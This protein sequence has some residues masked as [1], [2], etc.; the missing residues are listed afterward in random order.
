MIRLAILDD[1]PAIL[2]LI[3]RVVPLMR[4]TGNLQWDDQYPNAAVFENDIA[5]DQLWV[6][7]LDHQLVGLA[8]ITTDQE[9]EYAEVGWDLTETAVVVHR[10]AVDPAVRGRGIAA[11]LMNQAEEVA[12][13]RGISVLR[14]DTNTQNEATQRLFPKLGY[15]FAGEIGLSFRPG[16]RFYCYEKRLVTT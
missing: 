4:A 3:R 2:Q 16:L 10:L 13:Q 8:A 6:A 1:I 14:I 5:Q 9:P 12:R 15:Q 7:E 11:Q